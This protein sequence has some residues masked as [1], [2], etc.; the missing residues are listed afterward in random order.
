V[1]YGFQ[2]FFVLAVHV[3]LIPFCD[4]DVNIFLGLC[5]SKNI[6]IKIKR[7]PCGGLLN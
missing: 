1:E 4:T 2:R 7:R 5:M 6:L 3:K